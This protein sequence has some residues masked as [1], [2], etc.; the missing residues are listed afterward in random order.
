MTPRL[1]L[2]VDEDRIRVATLIRYNHKIAARVWP[3]VSILH[4]RVGIA[5]LRHAL[6]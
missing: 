4:R 3:P 1:I 5:L 6:R 2:K